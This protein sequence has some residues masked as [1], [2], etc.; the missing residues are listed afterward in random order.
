LEA[1]LDGRGAAERLEDAPRLADLA[2]PLT[3]SA[4]QRVTESAQA[5]IGSEAVRTIVVESVEESHRVA[6][7]IVREDYDS[8]PNLSV[9][10][11]AVKLDL[12]P[13]IARVVE[14]QAARDIEIAGIETSLGA[15]ADVVVPDEARERLGEALEVRLGPDF[16]RI[17][18]LSADHVQS[19]RRVVGLLD[20]AVWAFVGLTLA[21]LLGSIWM[22]GNRVRATLF[23]AVGIL[24]A[25]ATTWSGL[26]RLE[27]N[28]SDAV[29]DPLAA[30]LALEVIPATLS[31]LRSLLAWTMGLASVAV[32]LSLLATSAGVRS[33]R[34]ALGALEDG[35]VGRLARA[36]GDALIVGGVGLAVLAMMAFGWGP[37]GMAVLLT[38]VA[39]WVGAIRALGRDR[40]RS[41]T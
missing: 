33:I 24:L 23:L 37:L 13:I 2:G 30:A 17:T 6:V 32:V 31:G 16:G 5:V 8:T 14:R 35:R 27:S 22:A 3:S 4:R 11:E 29:D 15:L 19:L 26:R 40:D 39:A 1:L 7:A 25:L 41:G 34:I 9:I 10:D 28:L 38:L 18:V 12:S 20:A 36:Q 21:A